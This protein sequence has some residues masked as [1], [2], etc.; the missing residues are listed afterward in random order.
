VRLVVVG[1]GLEHPPPDPR[2]EARGYVDSIRAAYATADVVV[3]PLLQGGGSPL[4]FVEALAYGL[5]VVATDHAG[6]LLED[7]VAGEHFLSA[8]DPAGFAAA[9]SLLLQDRARAAAIGTAG[10]ELARRSYSIEALAQLLAP[11]PA[12]RAD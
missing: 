9:I 2:I 12:A 6:R 1:R 3:V 11:R 5:P 8:S 10:R 4:K 7:A